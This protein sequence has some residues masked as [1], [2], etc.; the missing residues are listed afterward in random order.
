MNEERTEL[1]EALAEL[2]YAIAMADGKTQPEE[3]RRFRSIIRRELKGDAWIAE[4]RF[5]I[6]NSA[7]SPSLNSAYDKALKIV[8]RRKDHFDDNMEKIF[9]NVIQKV[10]DAFQGE[11]ESE[12]DIIDKLKADIGK[13]RS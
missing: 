10:A 4:S 6:L 5:E 9:L 3:K 1:Y 8:Q 7:I 2:S 11:D 12:A 13:I